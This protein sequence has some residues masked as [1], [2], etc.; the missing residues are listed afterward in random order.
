MVPPMVIMVA[1]TS[2]RLSTSPA[3]IAWAP[4]ILPVG[5]SKTSLKAM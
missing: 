4:S 1:M 5:T 2:T 3:P